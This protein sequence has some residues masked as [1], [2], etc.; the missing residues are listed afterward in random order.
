M[1][2]MPQ[3][4]EFAQIAHQLRSLHTILDSMKTSSPPPSQAGGR[5]PA[6]SKPPGNSFFIELSV[7]HAQR[8]FELARDAA[9][10][11]SPARTFSIDVHELCKWFE[12]QAFGCMELEWA[13]DLFEE[14]RGMLWQLKTRLFPDDRGRRCVEPWVSARTLGIR[15]STLGIH[16][17][18]PTLATWVARGKVGCQHS[19]DGGRLYQVSDVLRHIQSSGYTSS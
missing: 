8:L 16:V 11:V 6:G 12:F 18:P 2:G 10:V 1:R 13:D 7:D 4:E 15:L 14:V 5:T 3:P 9:N 19:D 17:P